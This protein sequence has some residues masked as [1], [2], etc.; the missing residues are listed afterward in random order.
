MG[1]CAGLKSIREVNPLVK[2][3]V[4]LAESM[5]DYYDS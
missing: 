2:G 1:A 5:M 3:T 4:L